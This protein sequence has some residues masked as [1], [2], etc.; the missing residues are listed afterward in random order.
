MENSNENIIFNN[1]YTYFF[2]ELKGSMDEFIF[3]ATSMEE[4]G[5][6]YYDRILTEVDQA[7]EGI[8]QEVIEKISN[9]NINFS[10]KEDYYLE[11]CNIV[12]INRLPKEIL[13]KVKEEF[14]KVFIQNYGS[15]CQ[16]IDTEIANINVKLSEIKIKIEDLSKR[17]INYS[18]MRDLT[19]D[20]NRMYEYYA[21]CNKLTTRKEMIQFAREYT[22][23]K[24]KEFCDFTDNISIDTALK[25]ISINM[26]SN[27]DI[28]SAFLSYN[29]IVDA[30][31]DDVDRPY[32]LF[33]KVKIYTTYD[34]IKEK[35]ILDHFKSNK[36][37]Q[38][39]QFKRDIDKIP[40]ID[41]LKN[42]KDKNI[43]KYRNTLN[44]FIRD[45]DILENLKQT[46]ENNISLRERKEILLKCVDLYHQGEYEI[47]D[48][49][50]SIQIEGM[51]ADYLN[52]TS[53]FRKF[54]KLQVYPSAVLRDKI[55]Y[56]QEMKSD[57]YPEAV[58]YFMYYFN[59]LIRNKVAHGSYKYLYKNDI[60]AEVF[61]NEL[62]LDMNLL[63]Y[64]ISRKSETERMYRF[65][66]DYKKY[67]KKIIKTDENPHFG[68]LFND[69]IGDKIIFEYDQC[70]KY[71]PI[72][73]VYWIVN[74]YYE[75]LYE[76]VAD[77]SDL[78][79]LR[80][81]FL[82]KG[83][84]DYVLEE[85]KEII[86]AGYDYKNIDKEFMSIVKGLFRCN[87]TNEVRIVLGKVNAALQEISAMRNN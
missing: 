23:V 62:I 8:V 56:L 57:I 47:F 11:C 53:T 27:Y 61:A 17:T 25:K 29:G 1:I 31:K 80:K 72:Q 14:N 78:L 70:A 18:F 86:Q 12:G 48:N 44:Q 26:E 2:K 46:L 30:L 21:E 51:F 40:K 76:S 65:I 59:N 4:I 37:V 85:L 50:A 38:Y 84:W 20:E 28:E 9:K 10:R 55:K 73:V 33:F 71:S 35:Y 54:T 43:E 67:Y 16:K 15:V 63:T 52:N 77:K 64:M 3:N 75:K 83:F 34:K 81:D 36:Q 42:Q 22:T 58:E 41:D 5:K 69:L 39:E 32:A 74:P 13:E 87:I 79:E 24:L 68:A 60:Q 82:S 49:I 66:H 7:N 19:S 6:Y 45:Y